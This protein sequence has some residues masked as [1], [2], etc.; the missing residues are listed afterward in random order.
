[1]VGQHRTSENPE[2]CNAVDILPG[3]NLSQN[4]CRMYVNTSFHAVL[5][6]YVVTRLYSGV[7]RNNAVMLTIIEKPIPFSSILWFCTKLNKKLTGV[8]YQ[9]DVRLSEVVCVGEGGKRGRDVKGWRVNCIIFKVLII[10]RKWFC[11]YDEKLTEL[12]D[13]LK[14]IFD[15]SEN[16]L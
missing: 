6:A 7:D 14:G 13:Y 4:C 8:R 15:F 16:N 5:I 3:S 9:W 11:R 1:M 12:P 2:N 10:W